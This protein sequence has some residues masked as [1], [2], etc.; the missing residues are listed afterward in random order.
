MYSVGRERLDAYLNQAGAQI[1]W[2]R[3]RKSLLQELGHHVA[4]QELA[5]RAEGAPEDEALDRAVAEMGDPVEVGRA[6]DRLH[7]PQTRW[8]L[9]A[10]TILLLALG[11]AAQQL[12]LREG[13][14]GRLYLS[15]QIGGILAGAVLFVAAWLSDYTLLL[16][17]T[18]SA[19]LCPLGLTALG[20]ASIPFLTVHYTGRLTPS[21]P[22]YLCLLLPAAYALLLCRLRGRGWL[23]VLLLGL[24]AP[25]LTLPAL[26]LP[27]LTAALVSCSSMLL[28]LGGG[29]WSGW[30]S[31]GRLKGLLCAWG[32]PGS[33]AALC[34]AALARTSPFVSRRWEM[35]LHPELDPLGYG[36]LYLHLRSGDAV[37]YDYA[38][39]FDLMLSE[40]SRRPGLGRL[41][42]LLAGLL[43]ALFA[44]LALHR[45]LQL[46]STSGKL[47][48]L[49]AFWPLAL[50]AALFV[51]YNLGWSPLPPLSLPFLSYGTGYMAVNLLLA[52][53]LMSVLRMD[54][55]ARD[56]TPGGLNLRSLPEDFTLPLPGGALHISWKRQGPAN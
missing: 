4:D 18:W 46:R 11:L 24:S 52:G 2:R 28:V 33:L 3:A 40:L 35:F 19:V 15:R 56:G 14:D 44:V 34:L 36:W 7:R 23:S 53:V 21:V 10:F 48:A 25:L 51:L 5:Y 38:G 54:A 16:R 1:R 26:L 37:G 9:M 8:E 32:V 27:S 55:L 20:L 41:V 31:C 47:V 12:L 29:V 45:V 42:F 13:L 39:N 49:G 6:L 50:Q 43:L 22:L 30:F 17:R